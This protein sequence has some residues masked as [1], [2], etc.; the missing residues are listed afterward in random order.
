[1]HADQAAAQAVRQRR[2]REGKRLRCNAFDE[3]ASPYVR[4]ERGRD[5][6]LA[7]L[8]TRFPTP[9]CTRVARL[10]ATYLA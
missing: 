3:S 7:G 5:A 6:S 2:R 4:V 8:T 1:M 9:S 10:R